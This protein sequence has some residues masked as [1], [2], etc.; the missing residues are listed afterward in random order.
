M[1]H[2]DPSSVLSVYHTAP[3]SAE[4]SQACVLFGPAVTADI[5]PPATAHR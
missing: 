4:P 1:P 2:H 5:R 3:G